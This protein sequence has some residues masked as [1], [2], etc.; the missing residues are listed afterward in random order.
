MGRIDYDSLNSKLDEYK[1]NLRFLTITGASNVTG[2][3]NDIHKIAKLVHKA[4]GKIIVDGAQLVPHIKIN[5][6]GK[7]KK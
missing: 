7:R 4:G 6:S 3:V 5:M 1:G 2:Y